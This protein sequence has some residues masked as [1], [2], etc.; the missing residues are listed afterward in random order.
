MNARRLTKVAASTSVSIMEGVTIVAA[1]M[2]FLWREMESLVETI[3][4]AHPYSVNIPVSTFL[5]AIDVNVEKDTSLTLIR[6]PA[7][8]QDK[9]YK[10]HQ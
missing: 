2:D 4:S 10:Y 1:E 3:M 5:E 6:Y 7:T 9:L 8:V